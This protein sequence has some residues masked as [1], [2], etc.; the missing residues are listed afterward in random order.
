MIKVHKTK[1]SSTPKIPNS[2]GNK[3]LTDK[4]KSNVYILGDSMVKHTE[5]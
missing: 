1:I 3:L 5:G 4:E 2:Q